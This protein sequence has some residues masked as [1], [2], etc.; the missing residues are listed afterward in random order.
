[1][2]AADAREIGWEL[3][4]CDCGGDLREDWGLIGCDATAEVFC[5]ITITT[6]NHPEE[7]FLASSFDTIWYK[8]FRIFHQ[9]N[10]MKWCSEFA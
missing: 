4:G 9:P 8:S 7:P 6:I 2:G 1:M 3:I 5:C 10:E